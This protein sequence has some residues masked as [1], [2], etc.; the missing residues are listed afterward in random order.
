MKYAILGLLFVAGC[1]ATSSGGLNKPSVS[2]PSARGPSAGAS[3]GSSGA[4]ASAGKPSAGKP[5]VRKPSYPVYRPPVIRSDIGNTSVTIDPKCDDV[6][7]QN[8]LGPFF[9]ESSSG[10]V[11]LKSGTTREEFSGAVIDAGL[12]AKIDS[13][14]VHVA[15][16]NAKWHNDHI[17]AGLRNGHFDVIWKGVSFDRA[18]ADLNDITSVRL[19][20][21]V[22]ES[23]FKA[24]AVP[25]VHL[26]LVDVS[27]DY[28][29]HRFAAHAG[30]TVY[31][32]SSDRFVLAP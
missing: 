1:T 24:S 26:K 3:V 28:A 4:S 13:N 23:G 29:V 16:P 11:K 30:L 14:G 9:V 22:D 5:S 12:S 18:F 6:W 21:S 17:G 2:K 25:A 27:A 15:Q 31:V 10:G 8:T 32:E 19:D 7:I 20:A